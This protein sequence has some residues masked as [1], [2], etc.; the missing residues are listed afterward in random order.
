MYVQVSERDWYS[1]NEKRKRERRKRKKKNKE[2]KK[3]DKTRIHPFPSNA[4]S[5]SFNE[6]K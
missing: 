6:E 5:H 1:G 2:K 3:G 4:L